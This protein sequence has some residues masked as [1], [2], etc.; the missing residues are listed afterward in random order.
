MRKNLFECTPDT[1]VK[2]LLIY[3]WEV[4]DV[5][6]GSKMILTNSTMDANKFTI[7][8]DQLR[9]NRDYVVKCN[10][11][12]SSVRGEASLS[13]KTAEKASDIKLSIAPEA[14]GVAETTAFTLSVEKMASEDLSCRFFQQLDGTDVRIGSDTSVYNKAIESVN[15]TLKGNKNVQGGQTVKVMVFCSSK[16]M[17][18]QYTKSMN[19]FLKPKPTPTQNEVTEVLKDNDEQDLN[20][21][22][23]PIGLLIFA[24]DMNDEQRVEI[25][26]EMTSKLFVKSQMYSNTLELAT[27][28]KKIIELIPSAGF[29]TDQARD[30]IYT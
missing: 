20:S 7:G 5:F 23:D 26:T 29:K 4:L 1:P 16:D 28:T 13:I 15:S 2:D 6:K 27:I 24:G 17:K 18:A 10:A 12:S 14:I 9:F 8:V 22:I 21:I 30:R 25:F 3:Q 11:V 19:V